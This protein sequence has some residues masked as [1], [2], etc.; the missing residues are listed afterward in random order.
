MHILVALDRRRADAI[1]RIARRD[2]LDAGLAREFRNG[3]DG[4]FRRNV[5][6]ARLSICRRIPQKRNDRRAA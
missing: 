1:E 2:D 3:V 5:E 6:T 4:V